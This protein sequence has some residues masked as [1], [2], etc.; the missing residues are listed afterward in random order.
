MTEQRLEPG[1]AASLALN[2][3]S[4]QIDALI[5]CTSGAAKMQAESLIVL[6]NSNMQLIIEASNAQ[7]DEIDFLVDTL[8]VRDGELDK[9]VANEVILSK[10]LTKLR[11]GRLDDEKKIRAIMDTH[12]QIKNQRDN[13][14]READEVG[15]VKAEIKRLRAQAERHDAAQAKKDAELTAANQ[16]I[17]RLRSRLSPTAEAARGLLDMLRFTRQVLILEGLATEQTIDYNGEQF[18]VYRRPGDVTKAFN[19]SGDN[20]VS[21]EHMYYFR[22]ETNAGYHCDVVP[23]EGGDAAAAKHKALPAKVKA[24]LVSMFKEET[25]FDRDK[26]VMRSDAM[27]ERLNEI[28]ALIVPTE[29]I[30][31]SIE[32]ELITNQVIT[33]STVNRNKNKRRA[34]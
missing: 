25:L 2:T 15:K 31:S 24:H 32:K 12:E 11:A 7:V 23:L 4:A 1:A 34:A 18:H 29:I 13:Y 27:T 19:P 20:R 28:E 10:E 30:V 22:V 16:T 9:A 5:N 21:R 33:N 6:L 26:V 3:L 17:Q 8:H 14:K